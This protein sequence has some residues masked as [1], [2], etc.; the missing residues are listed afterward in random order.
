[1]RLPTSGPSTR[2][3]RLARSSRRAVVAATCVATLVTLVVSAAG[4]ASDDPSKEAAY[5][6][7]IQANLVALET[8]QIETVADIDATLELYRSI[9]AG[10]PLAVQPEWEVVVENLE[11]AATVDPDDQAS[12]QRAADTARRSQS[13]ATRIQQYT[14]E[15]CGL[16]IGTPPPTTNPVT[17]TTLV[18]PG[19][20][21]DPSDSATDDADG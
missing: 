1:M 17:A 19:D 16:D 5:C 15:S 20:S 3:E 8:P 9:T 2:G 11:T 4:C 14:H 12:R 21:V 10:A 7:T 6:S 13:A 18:A